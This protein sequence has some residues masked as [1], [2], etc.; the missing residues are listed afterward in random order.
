M[1]PLDRHGDKAHIDLARLQKAADAAGI[2]LVQALGNMRDTLPVPGPLPRLYV[3]VDGTLAFQPEGTIIAVNARYGTTHLVAE[4]TEYPW[5]GTLRGEQAEWEQANQPVVDANLA[6]DTHALDVLRR[7]AAHGYP[8]TACTERHPWLAG[9]TEAWLRY[10]AVPCD[11]VAVV[12]PGGKADLLAVHD[13][14]D[15]CIL[16]DDD[17][18][19][20]KLVRPG[21]QVWQPARPYNDGDGVTMRFTD[22][23]EAATALGL[24]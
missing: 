19:K 23:C 3:D 10:W 17:P 22:W 5:Y 18:G 15:P 2:G 21:V 4:A 16:I 11:L 24:A 13:E 6:P 7:A 12:G 1:S 14:Q 8:V 20:S 9:I